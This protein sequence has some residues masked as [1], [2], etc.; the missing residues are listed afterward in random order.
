MYAL[1]LGIAS[2]GVPVRLEDELQ[3][4][5]VIQ[6]RLEGKEGIALETAGG[7]NFTAWVYPDSFELWHLRPKDELAT[8]HV[9]VE[10]NEL[11]LLREIHHI[12]ES[13]KPHI[14]T[15]RILDYAIVTN[16]ENWDQ[17]VAIYVW[18]RDERGLPTEVLV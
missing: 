17:M 6:G 12:R 1:H 7:M 3:G 13:V 4:L 11:P 2:L 15:G 14:L 10:T 5:V 9:V 16:A 8:T 18:G